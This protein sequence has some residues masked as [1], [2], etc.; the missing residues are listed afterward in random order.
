MVLGHVV[1]HSL[2]VGESVVGL[3]ALYQPGDEKHHY[4]MDASCHV[5]LGAEEQRQNADGCQSWRSQ[6]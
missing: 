5:V 1:Q 4:Y 2:K 3:P 6:I